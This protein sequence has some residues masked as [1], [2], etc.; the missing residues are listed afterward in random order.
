MEIGKLNGCWEAHEE[1]KKNPLIFTFPNLILFHVYRSY[2]T[3][4]ICN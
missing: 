3:L 4:S 1:K 2:Y